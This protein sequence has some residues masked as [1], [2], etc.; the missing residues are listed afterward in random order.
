[1]FQMVS[2]A[3]R[4]CGFVRM[5][6]SASISCSNRQALRDVEAL[7]W[8]P[9]KLGTCWKKLF[10][11]T[12]DKLNTC[13]CSNHGWKT[14]NGFKFWP[15]FLVDVCIMHMKASYIFKRSSAHTFNKLHTIKCITCLQHTRGWFR[16]RSYEGDLVIN[17]VE[18]LLLNG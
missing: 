11:S 14:E 3:E 9:N 13:Y 10:C 6:L 2:S 8:E 4:K 18:Q 12:K 1:M 5:P 7:T 17:V 16:L 15:P